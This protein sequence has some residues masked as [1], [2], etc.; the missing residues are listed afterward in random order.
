[1]RGG[2]SCQAYDPQKDQGSSPRAWGCFRLTSEGWDTAVVFPTCVG[3]FLLLSLSAGKLRRLPHV[4]G[5]VSRSDTRLHRG[6][7]SSPRAWGCFQDHQQVKRRHHVFPTCV[8]V[9]PTA[10]TMGNPRHSLPHVRGGVS[11]YSFPIL[12]K[13]LSSPRAWGCFHFHFSSLSVTRVFPT[14]VG[15]FPVRLARLLQHERLPHVRGGVSLTSHEVAIY[16]SSSPR[17]WGCFSWRYRHNE[18]R[19][20]FPTCV[21]VF[22]FF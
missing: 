17:A 6:R 12:P 3:V 13:R 16:S 2:V 18:R 15:V 4:R 1:M 20:V 21:G 22:L 19:T 10:C 7:S 11:F 14:C 9:F 5:G 8:G